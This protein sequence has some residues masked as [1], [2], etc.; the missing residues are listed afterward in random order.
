MTLIK[1][2]TNQHLVKLGFWLVNAFGFGLDATRT[3]ATQDT[4]TPDTLTNLGL[5]MSKGFGIEL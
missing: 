4:W 1:A 2:W 5:E 3:T